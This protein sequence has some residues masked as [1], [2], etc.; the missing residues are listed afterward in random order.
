MGTITVRKLDDAVIDAIKR[1]AAA[2]G[3]SME[4]EAR[5]ALER[6]YGGADRERLRRDA[7]ARIRALHKAGS[8]PKDRNVDSVEIIREMR[9]DRDRQLSDPAAT[10]D[11]PRRRR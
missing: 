7:V 5:R 6:T 10:A 8:L 2:S 1:Q 4:E 11:G 9:E 3:R